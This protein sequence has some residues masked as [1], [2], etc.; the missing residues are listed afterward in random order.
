MKGHLY[1]NGFDCGRL[2]YGTKPHLVQRFYQLPPDHL[3]PSGNVLVLFDELASSG[4][5]L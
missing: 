2:W 3:R 4:A 1:I 5:T